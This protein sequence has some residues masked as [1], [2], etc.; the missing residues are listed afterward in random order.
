[1]RQRW[2]PLGACL[3]ILGSC[4]DFNGYKPIA[5]EAAGAAGSAASGGSPETGGAGGATGGIGGSTGGI[6]GSGGG[7]GGATGGTAGTGGSTG[8]TGATGGS[9]GT[10]GATGGA[11]GA[12]GTGGSGGST[13]GTGG[14]GGAGGSTGGTG[15]STGGTAGSG[16]S[17]G[18]T[19][20]TGATGGTGGTGGTSSFVACNGTPTSC[21]DIG[22]DQT[23]QFYGCCDGQT[24]YWCDD[25]SG[26][27]EIHELDCAANNQQ[28][29]FDSTYASMYCIGGTA[30]TGGTGGSTGGTG[31]STG[32]TG[33][34]GGTCMAPVSG[35]CD[36]SPQCGCPAGQACD[37]ADFTGATAC[38]PSQNVPISSYCSYVQGECVPGASCFTFGCKKL[39]EV[40]ADCPSYGKCVQGE[41]NGSPVPHWKLCTDQCLP[42]NPSATC[43]AGLT[44]SFWSSE[45]V[46]PGATV[47]QKSISTSTTTCT[48]PL[49]CAPGYTCL[50]DNMCYKFCRVGGSD[51][52]SS[53]TCFSLGAGYFVGTTE[54]GICDQ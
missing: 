15:G 19:G 35:P 38:F 49:H 16:G 33:G 6:G 54:V 30:G 5:R 9:G 1:M 10:G 20:G 53:Y 14:T 3:M 37:L 52:P 47:C 46:N 28:C 48:P 11:G 18:G 4:F 41:Q 45:G 2:L 51:C 40:N 43:G 42:W 21:L 50:A 31:G 32:G 7:V 26:T 39:C 22:S 13:G 29:D 27:W 36:T 24:V 17:T 44:C 12:S 34:T 25:Q 23:E 8:G